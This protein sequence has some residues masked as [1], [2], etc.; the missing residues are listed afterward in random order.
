MASADLTEEI[1]RLPMTTRVEALKRR[2]L[3]EPRYVS[4]EQAAI[5]T[6]TYRENPDAP[7]ILQRARA[8]RRAAEEITIRIDPDELIVGNRTASMRAGVVFPEAG[9]SWV[10]REL[11]SL[12]DRPQDP[13][14]VRPEDIPPF[15]LEILPFWS[16]TTLE[17]AVGRE[18]GEEIAAMA[19]VV[20]INQTDHAQGHVCPDVAGWLRLGAAGLRDEA[21]RKL[22]SAEREL[23]EAERR[24][25]M[26]AKDPAEVAKRRDFYEAVGTV[27]CGAQSFIRRY[28]DLARRMAAETFGAEDRANLAEIERICSKL[29]DRP[30]E[31]FREALQSVW[32]LFALLHMESNASSFSPGRIDQYLYR[33][34]ERDCAAGS[35]PLESAL[36]LVEALW[37]KFNQIVY[38]RNASSARY[39]AGF[40]IGFNVALGGKAADGSDATNALSYLFLKAQEHLGLPQPNVSARLHEGTPDALLTEC[41][42]VVGKGSGMPQI[43]NDESIIPALEKVGIAPV[44]A[45][46]YAVVGCVEL[47]TQGSSLGWSDAAMFNLVKALELALNDGRCLLTGDQLGPRTGRLTDH[48]SASELDEAFRRQIDHFMERMIRVCEV[49]D[50]LHAEYLP[51]PLLSAVVDGCMEKGVDITA[52][53]ARYNLSGIQAIQ[54]ANVADSLAAVYQTIYREGSVEAAALLRALEADYQGHEPLRQQLLKQV[55][56]YGNDVEWVDRIAS[57]WTAYFAERL[58]SRVNARGGPYHMGLYTV[59][60]HVPMGKNVGATPDGR[61]AGEPLADGGL[62]AVCGRDSTGPTALLRSVSRIDSLAASNGTL[63]NMKFLPQFFQRESDIEKFTSLLRAFVRLRIHH[64]QFNVV[65]REDLVAA[66]EDPESHR[67]LTVRVAGYTAYFTELAGELQDEIIARTTYGGA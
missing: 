46:D 41:A 14:E 7:R 35:L 20:K 33:Y 44:D 25:A 47:S 1:R 57:T 8:L 12:P 42:R 6:E 54:A 2:T 4:F 24:S 55:P 30:P 39:F 38:L 26:C 40:P 21:E 43:F 10:D 18:V 61:R 65:R 49:V 34:F 45:A 22:A 48:R 17:D 36:A 11:E 52:G 27:M 16:G 31:T 5:I 67:G 19:G 37:L 66:K 56:K 60:A 3:S 28:A 53:G 62:S 64:V 23:A 9:L 29:V 50:R 58:K 59:S 15:R 63:L 13:F 32:F 51:S